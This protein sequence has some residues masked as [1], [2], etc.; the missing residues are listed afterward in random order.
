MKGSM[1]PTFPQHP[2]SMAQSKV[3][4]LTRLSDA[5][6]CA[7]VGI[8]AIG[9]NFWPKSKRFHPFDQAKTWL[10]QVPESLT[11]VAVFVNAP[12]E[13]VREILS[14]GLIE[15]AQFHGDESEEY[16]QSFLDSDTPVIRALS[17]RTEADLEKIA[18]SPVRTIL[19]D[20]YQPG[21]YGGTGLTCDWELAARAVREFP[22]KDIILSGG[23]T[24]M[25]AAQAVRE[26]SPAAIDLASG[27]ESAPG[28]KDPE[29][30][31]Q[32]A[33]SLRF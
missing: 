11:R 3:C 24:P 29:A 13:E 31:R 5:L 19:L 2:I 4:G 8:N 7:E 17:A 21:V 32:L 28:V 15:I 6:V 18:R 9:I 12:P 33:I 20:A 23:L 25:N 14:S 16:V 26:V 10:A 30:I 1:R 22:E 27:V